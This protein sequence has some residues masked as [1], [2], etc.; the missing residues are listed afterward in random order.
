MRR[1]SRA[2]RRRTTTTFTAATAALAVVSAVAASRAHAA[3]PYIIGGSTASSG[4][5]GAQVYWN[6]VRAYGGFQCSGTVIASRWVL[7]ARHC[8]NAPGMHV[9]VGN[10]KLGAGT[11]ADVD[12]QLA[13]PRGDIALLHLSGSVGTT[14]MKLADAD[15]P[16]GSTGQIYGWGRT[17]GSSPP[18]STLKTA[19][20]RVTG[21]GIDAFGGQAIS[22]EG[23]DGAAWQG[24]SGGPEV[25][26]GFQVGVCSTGDNSGSD[27]SGTQNYASVASS[28]T[29]IRSTA[30]V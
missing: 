14:S 6:D 22:S 2:G 25:Y 11:P 4:S 9:L 28:R 16:T 29:W 5:W 12:R 23:I 7:T 17:R 27:P 10:V 20:V 30:G 19:N 8:L 24:D 26:K 13:S 15:P 3:G 1:A 18:A 21:T